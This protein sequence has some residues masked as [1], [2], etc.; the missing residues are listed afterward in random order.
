MWIKERYECL[1]YENLSIAL[2]WVLSLPYLLLD[3]FIFENPRAKILFK[4]S[5]HWCTYA[6]LWVH[7]LEKV[8]LRMF[9]IV[10]FGILSTCTII[11]QDFNLVT[12]YTLLIDEFSFFTLLQ[13]M[14]VSKSYVVI[15]K[16]TAAKN[17]EWFH[18]NFFLY[19]MYQA[20]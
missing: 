3:A 2:R 18:V 20:T 14:S 12:T 19:K 15:L 13:C 17:L 6:F 7:F 10:Y 5:L 9:L 8:S 4:M 1:S 11:A 16:A